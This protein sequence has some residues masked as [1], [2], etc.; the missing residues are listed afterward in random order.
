MN[1]NGHFFAK[2]IQKLTKIAA[3]IPNFKAFGNG[4]DS[5]FECSVL[6]PQLYKY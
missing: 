5:E 4:F 6:V 3:K 2:T 1:Q